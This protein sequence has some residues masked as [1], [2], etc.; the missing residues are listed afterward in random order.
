VG[1]DRRPEERGSDHIKERPDLP[2]PLLGNRR[3]TMTQLTH[4]IYA[5]SAAPSF[6]E[7]DIPALLERARM[8]NAERDLTGMLL[9]IDGSF[10]QVLEGDAAAVDE[11][12]GQILL[13]SR[14]TLITMIIR[15][16]VA[17]RSFSEWTMGFCNVDPLQAGE[18]IGENGFFEAASCVA[19]MNS[20]RAKK[21]LSAF[22]CGPRRIERTGRYRTIG[23]RA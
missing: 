7:Y 22:R 5:S 20:S 16:P 17:A 11:V 8:A 2:I 15:E 13:D 6:Q 19:R 9:Y 10:F 3:D 4:C 23:Q 1:L 12:Y 18:I 21:L 14:H